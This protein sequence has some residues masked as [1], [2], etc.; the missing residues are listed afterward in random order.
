MG[1]TVFISYSHKDKGTL[2]KMTPFLEAVPEVKKVL[3]FD[4]SEIDYG[5]RSDDEIRNGLAASRIG[6]LLI[7]PHFL[8]SEYIKT[9]ELP[10]LIEREERGELTLAIVYLTATPKGSLKFAVSIDGEQRDIDL[11][12]YHSFTTPNKPL[13][14]LD[15]SAQDTLFSK[16]ADWIN[17]KL[18]PAP[19][20]RRHADPGVERHQLAVR[21]YP[22]QVPL[23]ILPDGDR[24]RPPQHVPDLDQLPDYGAS[25]EQLFDLLFSSDP[26]YYRNLF[27]SAFGHE[28]P[29]EPTHSALR[30][31]LLLDADM[32]REQLD[33]LARQPWSQLA[34]AG[35]RLSKLDWTVELRPSRQPEFPEWNAHAFRFPDR[36]VMLAGK[37][38]VDA[39]HWQ[40]LDRFFG[41][42]WQEHV[43]RSQASTADE[44][45][46]AMQAGSPRL[47]YYHG[48]ADADGLRLES[49]V[50][51]WATL[52][53]CLEARGTVSLLH[54]NLIGDTAL[55]AL[56]AGRRLLESVRAAVLI[57]C[58]GRSD[59]HAS[60]AAAVDWLGDVLL[61]AVDPILALH[62]RQ[63]GQVCAWSRYVDWQIKP[64]STLPDDPVFVN[65][66]LDRH[67]Q[68]QTLHG[69]KGEFYTSQKD[70]R[71]HHVVAC[72]EAGNHVDEFPEAA[73]RYLRDHKGDAAEVFFTC[74]IR[75]EWTLTIDSDAVDAAV[76]RALNWSPHSGLDKALQLAGI[77]RDTFC[78]VILAWVLPQPGDD[79]DRCR[80]LL[81]AVTRWCRTRLGAALAAV[82]KTHNL[83]ILSILCLE[84][85]DSDLVEACAEDVVDLQSE[86]HDHP[87]FQFGELDVLS[88]VTKPDLRR[89][90]QNED[91]CRCTPEQ[92]RQFPDLL[93]GG[94][95]EMPFDQ[96]VAT[97]R[98][99]YPYNMGTLFDELSK[100]TQQGL[101]PPQ[102]HTADFWEKFDERS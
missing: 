38:R 67:R 23:F 100:L 27:R 33:H 30:L 45:A 90:F 62:Q 87:A 94:R 40:D 56:P 89:F 36:V 18:A 81:H 54:L 8:N 61:E 64:P 79:R 76:R 55:D 7:S 16:L 28:G 9:K 13:R 26:E 68:R 25:G 4:Q 19:K 82:E 46:E 60:A 43:P 35:R 102:R 51:D 41:R 71:I 17:G 58:A 15:R 95:R 47:V 73:T 70:A 66:E 29:A 53:D 92:R 91:R 69:A 77:G 31:H 20:D 78:F 88:G 5:D 86:D 80:E 85:A 42:H 6:I 75:L 72:G 93:L 32:G 12:R 39:S 1:N 96:A 74:P 2:E 50:L 21:L 49:G 65:L 11:S 14:K 34:F 22:G 52:A 57:Q 10:F 83:R 98:R 63:V 24:P 44:F 84:L 59:A 97:I 37:D 99:G 101:W 48:P 3:W